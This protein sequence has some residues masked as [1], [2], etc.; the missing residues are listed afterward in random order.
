MINYSADFP[1]EQQSTL[2]KNETNLLVL[3]Q[4]GTGKELLARAI[5]GMS[6]CRKANLKNA[7]AE[8][9]VF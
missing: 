2:W 3:N 7:P 8:N 9:G 5:H 4:I 6:L 1:N